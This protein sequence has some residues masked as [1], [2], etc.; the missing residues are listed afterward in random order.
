MSHDRV[1]IKDIAEIASVSFSTVSRC[2]NGHPLVIFPEGTRSKGDHFGEFKAGSMKLAT[3]AK[4]TIIPITI[5]DSYKVMEQRKGMKLI[6]PVTLTIHE[7]INTAGMDDEE[8]KGIPE[9]VFGIIQG[10]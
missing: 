4:A 5:H 1:T 7:P 2:L 3:R 9:R 10:S 6:T 8:L